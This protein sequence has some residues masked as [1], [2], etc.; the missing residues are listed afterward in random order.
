MVTD[1][2]GY[3][4]VSTGRQD[5]DR[6]LDALSWAGIDASRIYRDKN[7]GATADRPG[8][9]DVQDRLRHR[10][11][12]VVCTLDRLGRTATQTPDSGLQGPARAS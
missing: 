10:D 3:A 11:V 5:L 6:Q 7:S 1:G 4:R 9:I 2:Y 12:L 8:L